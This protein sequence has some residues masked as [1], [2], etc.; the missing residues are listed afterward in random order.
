[1]NSNSD[2]Q[3]KENFAT[4]QVGR[5]FAA[6]LVVFYHNAGSIFSL[7]K[8]WGEDPTHNFFNF[9]H[10]G[11]EFFFVL[12]GF[13]ITHV[14]WNDLDCKHKLRPYLISRFI[15]IYPFYWI[16]LLML[17]PVYFFIPSFGK[18]YE[19]DISVIMSSIS[20]IHFSN[21]FTIIPVAWTLYHEILFYLF[22]SLAIIN[23][24]WGLTIIF[25]WLT[26]S[27]T[28]LNL[29][30]PLTENEFQASAFGFYFSPLHL[31]FGIG[32]L[33]SLLLRQNFKINSPLLLAFGGLISF[34]IIGMEENF[35]QWLPSNYRS[36]IYGLCSATAMIGFVTLERQNKIRI[37]II[38]Q[39]MGNASYAIYLIHLALL[40]LLAKIFFYFKL[41]NFFSNFLSF[42]TFIFF[43]ISIG[44]VAHLLLE[45]K[46]LSVFKTFM[47]RYSTL[48]KN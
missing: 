16:V 8:Y 11:V 9:G 26:A 13:I 5:A 2:Y 19:R 36:L 27:I 39:R 34:F 46:I 43:S 10:S 17:L 37:P 4:L 18:G 44:M 28:Q 33:T 47:L 38:F 25:L 20:L 41:N 40:S 12:S 45:K 22:F 48:E 24:R 14:H 31:L 35:L 42:L 29:P 15:R 30:K 1:V 7:Q 23:K 21:G 6:I 32:M 3:K